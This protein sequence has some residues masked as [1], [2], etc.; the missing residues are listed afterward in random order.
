M[1][2]RLRRHQ[3]RQRRP[4]PSAAPR[5]TAL[6]RE[7]I[8]LDDASNASAAAGEA[9]THCRKA[10]ENQALRSDGRRR[11]AQR[12]DGAAAARAVAERGQRA[13]RRRARGRARRSPEAAAAAECRGGR[14]GGSTGHTSKRRAHAQA[15]E[16]A[17]RKRNA[18]RAAQRAP[19]GAATG[20]RGVCRGVGDSAS[21]SSTR[22]SASDRLS[23]RAARAL[24]RLADQ[25]LAGLARRQR[26]HDGAELAR[27]E[28]VPQAVAAGQQA[29]ADLELVDVVRATAAGPGCVPR[30]PVSRFDCGWVLASSS[31]IWPSSTRRCT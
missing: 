3:L 7:Q 14:A 25:H 27:G 13:P 20:T 1:R 29:V 18:E 28:V 31:V 17:V 15:H 24:A 4:R 30:Q 2:A 9:A 23:P 16:E 21:A 26:V 10:G 5:S 19:R 22:T 6:A 12:S 11:P 8:A